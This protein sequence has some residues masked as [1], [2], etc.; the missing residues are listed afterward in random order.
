MRVNFAQCTIVV[1]WRSR[2]FVVR[3]TENERRRRAECSGCRRATTAPIPQAEMIE[4]LVRWHAAAPVGA[5][6]RPRSRCTGA[7]HRDLDPRFTSAWTRSRYDRRR[8][9]AC[10]ATIPSSI[11]SSVSISTWCISR[12]RLRR[13]GVV[14]GAPVRFWSG[15]GSRLRVWAGLGSCACVRSLPSLTSSVFMRHSAKFVRLAQV[16]LGCLTSDERTQHT[17][18]SSRAR[19]RD[20]PTDRP[21]D[22]SIDRTNDRPTDR[23][24]RTVPSS[25]CPGKYTRGNKD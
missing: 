3:S 24:Y 11:R 23:P 5:R 17:G 15:P 16:R 12:A 25:F 6:S 9:R 21:T 13:P 22:R 1:E 7:V 20:R 8:Y 4:T 10:D 14:P 2:S 18:G 19:A